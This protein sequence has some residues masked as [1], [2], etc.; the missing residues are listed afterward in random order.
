MINYGVN[1]MTKNIIDSYFDDSQK[2]EDDS[3]F[4]YDKDDDVLNSQIDDVNPFKRFDDEFVNSEHF[5]DTGSISEYGVERVSKA[6]GKTVTN[7]V[8]NDTFCNAVTDWNIKCELAEQEGRVKPKMP[9]IIGE[10]I[11]RIADGLSRR[12]NF[13]NYCV[14]EETE[15]LT[16]RG[17]LKYNEITEDDIILSMDVDTKELKWSKIFEIFRNDYDGMMFKLDSS[18]MDALVTP[19]HKFVTQDGLKKVEDILIKDHIVT[20]GSPLLNDS[21]LYS[22]DLVA[23]VGWFVTEGS[24]EKYDRKRDD[25]VSKY[26]SITQSHKMNQLYCDEIE[27]HL[28]A[29]D[30]DG[31]TLAKRENGICD[32]T[33]K[34]GSR[35]TDQIL[36]AIDDDKQITYDFIL[37]I[38]SNQRQLLIDTMMKG[39]GTPKNEQYVQKSK[40][41]IDRFL[42]LCALCGINTHT[43]LRKFDS[44]FGYTECYTITLSDKKQCYGERVDFHGGR[45]S[46]LLS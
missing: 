20:N 38:N 36:S 4:D 35:I 29:V 19:E 12:W 16:Q 1:F 30:P 44:G 7:Y 45:R 26:L 27:S 46:R 42:M 39:D 33:I 3:V 13:R 14:D 41:H 34:V 40:K 22:D 6:T 5:I 17:W 9:D 32:F 15:A 31:Y 18:T 11:I 8:D 2:I 37:P 21:S 28:K 43:S 10:Y 23:L 25:G 24:I